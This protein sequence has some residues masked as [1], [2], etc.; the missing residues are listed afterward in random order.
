MNR[1]IFARL[2]PALALALVIGACSATAPGPTAGFSLSNEPLLGKF[3]WHDLVTDDVEK[4]RRFYGGLLG[5]KF[6]KSTHPLGG[7]YTLIT[8]D[9]QYLGGMVRLEDPA[10]ADYSRWLP[11]LSVA[12]VDAAVRFAETAGGTAV[13]APL[14]LGNIGRAAAITDP[15]GAVVGLLRSRVGDP[16]DSTESA[17]GRIVWN[18]LLAAE[19]GTA[20]RFYGSLAGL[21]VST[22]SRRGGEYTLLR[23]Q[24]RDR[25]GVMQ[26]PDP[27]VTPLWLTYF[28]VDDVAAS[29]RRVTELGGEVLLAPSPDLREGQLAVV[30]D[31]NGAI[32][33]LQ[34]W[35]Q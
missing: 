22:I 9:G 17:A 32:L 30:T 4:A 6:E 34:Q 11:Y 18:E 14:D 26:R 28:A 19:E 15:E 20:A 13:V 12:D 21:E 29:A 8:L 5:W 35:P 25:A 33:A 16:D 7:D 3:V 2:L 10:E 1:M 27:R 24:G 31:P 23:A